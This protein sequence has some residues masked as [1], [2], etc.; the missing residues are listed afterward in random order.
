MVAALEPSDK[1]AWLSHHGITQRGSLPS[2]PILNIEVE[3]TNKPGGSFTALAGLLR[4]PALPEP[5]Q[6]GDLLAALPLHLPDSS[7]SNRP[8]AIAVRHIEQ[9]GFAVVV[10]SPNV[11]AGTGN[12]P[13]LDGVR[14]LTIEESREML[15]DYIDPR[16]PGLRGMEPRPDGHP[17]ILVGDSGMQP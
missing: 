15:A 8:R 2:G 10:L 6:M 11:I 9:S 7:W 4:S 16:Y 14:D 3:Q 13:V 5:V 12:W 1:A 17:Q